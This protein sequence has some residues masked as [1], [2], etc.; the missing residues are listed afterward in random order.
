MDIWSDVDDGDD[1]GV[2]NGERLL[3]NGLGSGRDMM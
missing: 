2:Q 1:V 3:F